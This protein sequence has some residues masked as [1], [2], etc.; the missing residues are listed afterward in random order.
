M[1]IDA[2]DRAFA[3]FGGAGT[4]GVPTSGLSGPAAPSCFF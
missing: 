4:P 2:H 3:F 1:V